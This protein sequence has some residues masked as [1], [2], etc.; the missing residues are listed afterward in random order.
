[1]ENKLNPMFKYSYIIWTDNGIN[2]TAQEAIN[3]KSYEVLFNYLSVEEVEKL[4][5]GI[6]ILQDSYLKQGKQVSLVE[7]L[8]IQ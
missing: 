4:S 5:E 2:K 6:E 8:K 1:M 3:N 7:W